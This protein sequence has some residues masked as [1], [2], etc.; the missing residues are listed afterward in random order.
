MKRDQE[1]V[2][3]MSSERTA[4]EVV[5]AAAEARLPVAH[6]RQ[7]EHCRHARRYLRRRRAHSSAHR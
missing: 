4:H 3:N 2:E 1:R 7:V 5:E 6:R